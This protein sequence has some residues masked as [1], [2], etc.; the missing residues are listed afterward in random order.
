MLV[1]QDEDNK[2]RKLREKEE[3]KLLYL[4]TADVLKKHR[5]FINVKY[6]DFC[7]G[8]DIPMSTYNDILNA[9]GNASFYKIAQIVKAL[10]LNFQEFGKLLDEKLPHQFWNED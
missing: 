2:K 4:A 10:G 3:A 1:M 8:N 7:Y 5:E 6:T 9:K